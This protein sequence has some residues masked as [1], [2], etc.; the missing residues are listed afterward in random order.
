MQI[1]NVTSNKNPGALE[2]SATTGSNLNKMGRRTFVINSGWNFGRNFMIFFKNKS[3]FNQLNLKKQCFFTENIHGGE[4]IKSVVGRTLC[5]K[6][7][8]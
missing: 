7:A 2:F 6:K 4:K 8:K 3:Q 5:L 1:S